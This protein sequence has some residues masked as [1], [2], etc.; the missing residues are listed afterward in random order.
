MDIQMVDE[1]CMPQVWAIWVRALHDH[2]EAFGAS[3]EWAKGVPAEQTQVLLRNI[4][5]GGGFLLGAFE[6][7]TPVGMLHFNRQQGDKFQHKGDIGAVYVVPEQRGR[8]VAK[9]LFDSAL[10]HIRGMN[11][12]V[13]VSLSV[14]SENASAI[15]LYEACGFKAYGVEPKGLRIN[16]RYIDLMHMTIEVEQR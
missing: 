13:A 11:G 4:R 2:P 8:G 15:R 6:P 7:D 16:G 10:E 5:A 1:A 3:Y 12:V 14:N 9:A